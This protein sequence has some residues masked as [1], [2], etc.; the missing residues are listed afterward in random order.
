MNLQVNDDT[1]LVNKVQCNIYIE[2]L[3]IF[4]QNNRLSPSFYH[5]LFNDLDIYSELL[6]SLSQLLTAI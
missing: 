2:I 5:F 1:L 3:R 4:Y 6:L